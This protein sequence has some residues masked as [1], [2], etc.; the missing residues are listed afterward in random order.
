VSVGEVGC[1]RLFTQ[2]VLARGGGC[3][4]SLRVELVGRGDQHA[5]DAPVREHVVKAAERMI[6]LKFGCRP[7]CSYGID[8]C[9][10]DEPNFR[11]E[12]ADVFRV[13]PP[14][15]PYSEYPDP[16]FCDAQLGLRTLA[17]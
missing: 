14:H 12:A 16:Q 10:S 3:A 7:L 8:V 1:Q 15:F 9:H 4:N 11:N 6:D 13:T 2:N 17:L 5:I